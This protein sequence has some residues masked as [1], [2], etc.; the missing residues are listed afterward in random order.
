MATLDSL[1]VAWRAWAAAGA[2]IA[3]DTRAWARPTRLQGWTVK[4]LYAHHAGFPQTVRRLAAA[5]EAT[6][7]LTHASADDLLVS[8]NLPGGVA[9]TLA[10]QVRETAV[11]RARERP[12]Q[13]LTAQFATVG[14]AALAAARGADPRRPV[15]YPS[16]AVVPFGEALRVALLEA[17]V[18]YLDLARAL[19]LPAPGPVDGAP[20]E[21]TAALLAAMAD[22]LALVERAAGR[23]T[24][25]VFPVLR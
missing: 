19:D 23:T 17:V 5:P 21:E 25:D 4:D 15:D 11:A 9:H 3:A 20:L 10:D 14:P 22:P 1:E 13:D 12:V 6:R 16:G 7:P 8:F 18:H 24:T 2:Q